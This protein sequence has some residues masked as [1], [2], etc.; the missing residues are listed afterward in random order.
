MPQLCATRFTVT[1]LMG[2]HRTH[3]GGAER[4]GNLTLRSLERLA[5]RLGVEVGDVMG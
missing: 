4:R 2:V 1:E 5:A 3:M